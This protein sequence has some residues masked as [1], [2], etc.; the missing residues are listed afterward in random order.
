MNAVDIITIGKV[1]RALNV[2][3][4]R[5]RFHRAVPRFQEIFF[6]ITEEATPPIGLLLSADQLEPKYEIWEARVIWSDGGFWIVYRD[7][8][9][10]ARITE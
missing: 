1:A 6:R 7:G 9:E 8:R 2:P 3:S 10:V 4:K 5:V